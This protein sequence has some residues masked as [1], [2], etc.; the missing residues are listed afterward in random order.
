VSH[1]SHCFRESDNES[2]SSSQSDFIHDSVEDLDIPKNEC[3]LGYLGKNKIISVTKHN[4]RKAY[5]GV[6][7]K[8]RAF[9]ELDEGMLY[10]RDISSRYLFCRRREK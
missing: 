1:E 10:S 8:L 7:S 2:V 3:V 5:K 6:E 4:V 9:L